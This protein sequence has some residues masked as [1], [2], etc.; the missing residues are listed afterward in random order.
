MGSEARYG[1][2]TLVVVLIPVISGRREIYQRD[3][4]VQ[5]VRM[6]FKSSEVILW[7]YT[8]PGN[9]TDGSMN[10]QLVWHRRRAKDLKHGL[11]Q[12]H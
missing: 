11:G 6:S 5:E 3:Q 10:V 7:I 9:V 1:S 8:S 2:W 4:P 12:P